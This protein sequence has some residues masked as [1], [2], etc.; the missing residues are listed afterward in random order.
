[1]T[2]PRRIVGGTIWAKATHV[3]RDCRRIYDVEVDKLWLKG[4]VM[5]V[6]VNRP[7][8]SRWATT[9]IKAKFVVGNGKRV[10]VIIGLAQT[11]KDNLNPPTEEA[12][13]SSPKNLEQNRNGPPPHPPNTP[14]V[15]V[16]PMHPQVPETVQTQASASTA[17]TGHSTV[18]VATCHGI[19]WCASGDKLRAPKAAGHAEQDGTV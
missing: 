15:D 1:M 14:P 3:S 19:D 2:D 11:K 4:T 17:S 16:K 6:V 7:E 12:A 10:K 5:E 13:A 9:M 8:G 18:P